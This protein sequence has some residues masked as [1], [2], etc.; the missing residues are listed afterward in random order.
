MKCP[1]CKKE[2][3]DATIA[4]HFAS[5]G[6]RVRGEAKARDPEKMRQAA[7]KR[8]NKDRPRKDK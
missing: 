1:K 2:I 6:G 7:L 8:W 3:P 4:K 5:K